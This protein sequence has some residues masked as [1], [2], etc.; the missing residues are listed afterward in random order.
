M[1]WVALSGLILEGDGEGKSTLWGQEVG[2][3][4]SETLGM[5]PRSSGP[6]FPHSQGTAVPNDSQAVSFHSLFSRRGSRLFSL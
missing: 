2:I 1:T 4:W 3:F 6:W 5:T